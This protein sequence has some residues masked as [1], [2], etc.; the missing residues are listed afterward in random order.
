VKWIF[1]LRK[2][3]KFHDGSDFNAV[4]AIWNLDRY[5][6]KDAKQFDPPGSAVAQARNPFVAGYP[7]IDDSRPMRAAEVKLLIADTEGIT[8]AA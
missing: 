3:V 5:F 2:G 6:K 4:G 7:Q 8:N 1:H